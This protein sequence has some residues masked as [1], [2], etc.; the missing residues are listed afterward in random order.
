M[1]K[2]YFKSFIHAIERRIIR[3]ILRRILKKERLV[4]FADKVLDKIENLSDK[5]M[6][7]NEVAQHLRK[8][9][10]ELR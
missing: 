4:K 1:V 9:L 8:M 3:F 6:I 7:D 10:D 2:K 5:T